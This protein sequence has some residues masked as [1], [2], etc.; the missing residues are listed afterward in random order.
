MEGK[1]ECNTVFVGDRTLNASIEP[2]ATVILCEDGHT[3]VQYP[4]AHAFV[5]FVER[6][7]PNAVIGSSIHE[8]LRALVD[9]HVSQ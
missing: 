8:L 7:G 6:K 2:D 9:K 4:V 5:A 3:D 1:Y